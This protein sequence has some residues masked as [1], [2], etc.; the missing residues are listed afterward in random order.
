MQEQRTHSQILLAI[1]ILAPGSFHAAPHLAWR[2]ADI[3]G[4]LLIGTVDRLVGTEQGVFAFDAQLGAVHFVSAGGDS[5]A[6]LEVEGEAPGLAYGV[7]DVDVTP[8]AD[9]L[10]LI[11][12]VPPARA[13]TRS[14]IV[15]AYSSVNRFDAP[16]VDG[17]FMVGVSL[18]ATEQGLVTHHTFQM[19]DDLRL[20]YGRLSFYDHDDSS[21]V[22]FEKSSSGAHALVGA[23]SWVFDASA[24]GTVYLNDVYDVPIL[25][26]FRSDASVLFE[27]LLETTTVRKSAEVIAGNKASYEK[28]SEISPTL[29][30]D[31]IETYREIIGIGTRGRPG[32]VCAVTAAGI[33]RGKESVESVSWW[34]LDGRTGAVL[35]KERV[36]LP[37]G[38]WRVSRVTWFGD[39]VYLLVTDPTG[40]GGFEILAL[41]LAILRHASSGLE[42][43][44]HPRSHHGVGARFGNGNGGGGSG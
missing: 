28:L 26:A 33:G 25:R 44:D 21:T 18:R 19:R 4:G 11:Q 20:Q 39:R 3:R 30:P 2:T 24:D 16:F 10:A 37:S 29:V 8:S 22:I 36:S 9:R 40:D 38:R 6:L 5:F 35:S 34:V 17:A 14:P 42:S 12:S 41:D 43:R 15:P 7:S 27:T 1:A 32:T 31:V 23:S 13:W